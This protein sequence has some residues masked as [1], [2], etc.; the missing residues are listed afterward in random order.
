MK[1]IVDL[2][3]SY[4]NVVAFLMGKEFAFTRILAAFLGSPF[5]Y[6]YVGEP[7]A[8]GQISLENALEIIRRMG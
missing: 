5:I 1:K 4:D 2:L 8:P 3:V 6:C 7:K